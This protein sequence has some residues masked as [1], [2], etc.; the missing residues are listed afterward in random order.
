M[1]LTFRNRI[2]Y[3]K[4]AKTHLF[5]YSS[6]NRYVRK[7]HPH[8]SHISKYLFKICLLL[9]TQKQTFVSPKNG[10]IITPSLFWNKNNL[11]LAWKR[12]SHDFLL[13]RSYV[14]ICS[15]NVGTQTAPILYRTKASAHHDCAKHG[16]LC[17]TSPRCQ[18]S[19]WNS[20]LTFS[21]I[22]VFFFLH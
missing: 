19:V 14:F 12:Y 7:K 15:S 1:E 10:F 18:S 3:N 22:L 8:C 17:W 5:R 6:L 16:M 4:Y 2:W 9:L 21:H 11:M 20:I 13:Y